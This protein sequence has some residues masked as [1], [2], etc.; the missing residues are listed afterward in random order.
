MDGA[1][2]EDNEAGQR[3]GF[4]EREF[5]RTGGVGQGLILTTPVGVAEGKEC[6]W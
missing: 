1:I 6:L 5:E 2:E 3:S 4:E